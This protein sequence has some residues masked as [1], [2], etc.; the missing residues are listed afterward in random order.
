MKIIPITEAT[1]I[2]ILAV[3][4]LA[5]CA[6]A[7]ADT[8]SQSPVCPSADALA[9]AAG[10]LKPP[11]P[12]VVFL[13]QAG[14]KPAPT[15]VSTII[16]GAT[17]IK[18]NIF[19]G[20]FGDGL[21]APPPQVNTLLKAEGD[22]DTDRTT[23]A[24][25]KT[26]LVMTAIAKN[27]T[28]PTGK[29]VDLFSGLQSVQSALTGDTSDEKDVVLDGWLLSTGGVVDLGA[30]GAIDT[31]T[32]ITKTINGVA[33]A[34]LLPHCKGWRVYGIN[35]QNPVTHTALTDS[36]FV[37][38]QAFWSQLF[39][40]C[41]GQLVQWTQAL[42]TF[43][44]R[45]GA[46]PMA[47]TG[48][49]DIVHT[50]GRVIA[51]VSDLSFDVG[52]SALKSNADLAKLLSIIPAGNSPVNVDGYTDSTGSASFNQTLSR[53]RADAVCVW[54]IGHGVAAG[55]L[56]SAGHGADKPLEPNDS[57]VQRQANRRV[58]VTAYS[59]NLS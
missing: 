12:T 23:N 43:P 46:L 27:A 30:P 4:A 16:S 56:H 18:A 36:Q 25:C 42:T 55:R 33:A 52:S 22:N 32:G 1:L 35:G 21:A 40:R 39:D 5:G 53:A 11:T 8:S 47:D 14:T 38:L 17:S 6:S 58:T 19:I 54:L 51:T 10:S 28:L 44:V 2:S 7:G 48:Q 50:E 20:G 57:D 15:D 9:P 41:G 45:T 3:A 34:K 59:V 26:D 24:T 31:Q 13:G 49:I 37:N 29:Q